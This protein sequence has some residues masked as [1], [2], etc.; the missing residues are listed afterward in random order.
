M[1]A[2]W[3]S[4]CEKTNLETDILL[5][6]EVFGVGDATFRERSKTKIFQM[7]RESNRTVVIVTHS[8]SILKQLC[9]RVLIVD[10]GRIVANGNPEM[11]DAYEG[12]D[13]GWKGALQGRRNRDA[14]L[15]PAGI[16]RAVTGR[17]VGSTGMQ[18]HCWS[19]PQQREKS[20]RSPLSPWPIKHRKKGVYGGLP[21]HWNLISLEKLNDP[22][23]KAAQTDFLY[24]QRVRPLAR[25]QGGKL[26]AYQRP[27]CN[28]GMAN[29][30]EGRTRSWRA[31]DLLLT[32]STVA[33]LVFEKSKRV[34]T[35]ARL[36]LT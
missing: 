19:K 17:A 20:R 5:I 18:R 26:C 3:V 29:S 4:R 24:F 15:G 22:K 12:V 27:R 9:D 11:I 14:I 23:E 36:G 7:V 2:N 10:D 13:T 32:L 35:I 8:L 33:P 6:D 16:Q 34:F 28:M 1:K 31:C 30:G 21:L 25:L